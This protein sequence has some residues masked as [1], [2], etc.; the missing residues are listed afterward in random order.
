MSAATMAITFM[1]LPTSLATDARKSATT[2]MD[3]TLAAIAAVL[4]LPLA[5]RPALRKPDDGR[6]PQRMSSP[7]HHAVD[8]KSCRER[9]E[10]NNLRDQRES[11]ELAPLYCQSA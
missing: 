10:I 2:N 3:A 8:Q 7:L 6:E 1:A 4:Q 5:A 11:A 9:V